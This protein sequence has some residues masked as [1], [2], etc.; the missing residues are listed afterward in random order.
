MDSVKCT[1]WAPNSIDAYSNRRLLTIIGI[2]IISHANPRRRPIVPK[3][4]VILNPT[5]VFVTNRVEQIS[6]RFGGIF[7][8]YFICWR[9]DQTILKLRNNFRRLLSYYANNDKLYEQNR[10]LSSLSVRY[11]SDVIAWRKIFPL[12]E[13][14]TTSVYDLSFLSLKPI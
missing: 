13:L 11:H 10:I 9:I 5:E 14:Q 7:L 2:N 3:P 8:F 12:H 4:E 1:C 6:N